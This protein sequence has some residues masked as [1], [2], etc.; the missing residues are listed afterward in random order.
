VERERKAT[1]LTEN[2]VLENLLSSV[3]II[4]FCAMFPGFYLRRNIPYKKWTKLN[5]IV[6]IIYAL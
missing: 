5:L 3:H 6:E 1:N 2:S 4:L